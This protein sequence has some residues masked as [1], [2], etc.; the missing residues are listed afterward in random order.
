MIR[1]ASVNTYNLYGDDASSARCRRLENLLRDLDADIYAV[2]EII[3]RGTNTQDKHPGAVRG[4]RRLAAALDWS[5]DIDG[6]PAVAVGGGQHHTG[7]LW[8]HRLAPEPGSINTLTRERG[9]HVAL[10]GQRDIR[11]RRPAPAG[12]IGAA[13]TLRPWLGRG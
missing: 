10:R 2:Q 12:G 8:R 7:L 5:Y 11:L 1:I 6:V 3:A 13:I 9:G 4:L